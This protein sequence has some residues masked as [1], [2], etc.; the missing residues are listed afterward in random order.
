M[1]KLLAALFVAVSV[2]TIVPAAQAEEGEVG[3]LGP[4]LASY[5]IGPRAGFQMNDGVQIRTFEIIEIF[6]AP[7][8]LYDGYLAWDG[9]KWSEIVKEENLTAKD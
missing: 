4:C 3:G 2:A 7:L 9:K 8:R 5:Y 1:K 6:L